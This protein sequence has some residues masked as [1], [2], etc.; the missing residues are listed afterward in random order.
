MR[1]EGDNYLINTKDIDDLIKRLSDID[2]LPPEV[3]ED[4]FK[5]A[6]I[7]LDKLKDYQQKMEAKEQLELSFVKEEYEASVSLEDRQGIIMKTKETIS[8]SIRDL[9]DLLNKAEKEILPAI[10]YKPP[11]PKT[12]SVFFTLQNSRY[13]ISLDHCLMIKPKADAKNS[14]GVPYSFVNIIPGLEAL[15]YWVDGVILGDGVKLQFFIKSKYYEAME[16]LYDPKKEEYRGEVENIVF[17]FS[18]Y[19]KM[20]KDRPLNGTERD[21]IK[22]ELKKLGKILIEFKGEIGDKSG[23]GTFQLYEIEEIDNWKYIRITFPEK[24]RALLNK[25]SLFTHYHKKLYRIDTQK[26]RH[27]LSFLAFFNQR[28]AQNKG[29]NREDKFSTQEIMNYTTLPGYDPVKTK[30]WRN[31]IIKPFEK[32]MDA[33]S[34]MLSWEYTS[35]GNKSWKDWE[36]AM[37]R[38]IWKTEFE[39]QYPKKQIEHKKKKNL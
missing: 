29:T 24:T 5:F 15:V 13:N 37:F 35:G 22:E 7:I 33:L 32:N 19:A 27:S 6:Q 23:S 3:R 10:V 17:E 18:E 34:D 16:E 36:T 25:G 28:K 11:K 4:A 2:S 30:D 12:Q 1:E 9:E 39:P 31:D 14:Q 21:N 8:K 38:I 20:I 26:R